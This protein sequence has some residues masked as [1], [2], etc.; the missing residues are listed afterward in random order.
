MSKL[1]IVARMTLAAGLLLACFLALGL[2]FHHLQ[3]DRHAE[4]YEKAR[5][6]YTAVAHRRGERGLIYDINGNLLVGNTPCSDIV[7][8]PQLTGD[9]ERCR[10]LAA[11]LAKRLGMAPGDLFRRLATRT[12]PD[13]RKLRYV[14]IR[15]GVDLELAE[16]IR[17][18]VRKQRFKGVFF[19][20][21][22]TRYYPKNEMLAQVLGFINL[23]GD[24]EIAVS[25]IEKA[26]HSRLSARNPA[27]NHY[28]RDRRGMPLSYGK[29][30]TDEPRDGFNVYL[31]INEQLQDLVEA[32]LDALCSKYSPKAAYAIMVDPYTG[33]ILAL[34]QRPTFNP[35][36]RASMD[37]ESWRP[38]MLSDIFEPGSTMKPFAIAGALD[39]GIISPD[40]VFDCENGLW[41]FAGRTLRDV[42]GYGRLSV[43]QIIQ[44]SSNIGTAKIA[45]AMGKPRLYQTLRRFGFG[46]KTGIPLVPESRGIFR[47]PDQWD[48]LSISR[49]PIGQGIAS[50]P[51][52]LARAYCALANGGRLVN[53]RLIDSFEDPLT[54]LKVKIPMQ[55]APKA[56]LRPD[57]HAKLLEML[58]LVC[59]DGGTATR[60]AVPGYR[61]AGKTGTSQ[62]AGVGGY[63]HSDYF[64]TFVGFAPADNP[65]FVLLVT[66]DE[67]QGSHYG[68]VVA[69]PYFQSIAHQALNYLNIAPRHMVA[70]LEP[71]RP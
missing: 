37:P 56:F 46:E 16:Q 44:K 55:P 14:V 2:R 30:E 39:H 71:G 28:E 35:N 43:T 65:A 25:G 61:I 8:D 45:I 47:K 42:H 70:G 5:A 20:E 19:E 17:A 15:R 40:T 33:N 64:A 22:S 23:D 31:T 50:T 52:Q 29:A 49:F 1:G 51:L 59:E 34:G 12:R 24:E 48:A 54:G 36:D 4:L 7:A 26:V 32:E 66:A 10:E 38:R 41:F 60:A 18:D 6:K 9:E 63:S 11:F 53:L 27:S 68:G 3:V 21:T 58:T 57:T 62:K 67:P 13:G 69:A